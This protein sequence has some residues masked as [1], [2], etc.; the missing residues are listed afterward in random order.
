VLTSIESTASKITENELL[1]LEKQLNA[2]LPLTYRAFLL[3]TNGGEPRERGVDF[4]APKL[5]TTGDTIGRFS[6]VSDNPTYG[7]AALKRTFGSNVPEGFVCIADSPGGN[8]F[9]I[10]L[11]PKS[12]GQI[13]Y[14]DHD[15]EDFTKFDEVTNQLPESIV[16]IADSFDEFLAGLYDVD[17]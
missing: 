12:Y 13:F 5:R 8:H 2:K 11:R 3:K 6:E 15:F 1:A 7:I 16:K 4:A 9:F 14:K 10:S 17:S